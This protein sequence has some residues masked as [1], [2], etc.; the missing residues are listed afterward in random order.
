MERR[1]IGKGLGKGYY[2]MLP[3]DS[4]VHSL[5]ARGIKSQQC[6]VKPVKRKLSSPKLHI[7]TKDQF[8]KRFEDDYKPEEEGYA[9]TK[10]YPDGKTEIF[11][12][13]SGDFQRNM[14]LIAHEFNELSIW[15]HLVNEECIDPSIADEM[16]HNLNEIKVEG[17]LDTYELDANN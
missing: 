14:K 5:S 6:L 7:L 4:Y 10:I 15:H 11:L 12:K 13:D 17:V 1:N 8:E 3:M 16:A 9:T 2:N